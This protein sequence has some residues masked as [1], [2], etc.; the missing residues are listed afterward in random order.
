MIMKIFI[1]TYLTGTLIIYV[2]CAF[3][4]LHYKKGFSLRIGNW[5]A[6]DWL[7]LGILISFVGKI[8][9]AMYWQVAWTSYLKNTSLK[10][11]LLDYGTAANLPL[12]QLPI[13]LAC[14]CH[15]KA[16]HLSIADSYS[17]NKLAFYSM[18]IGICL[19]YSLEFLTTYISSFF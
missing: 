4:I 9:D 17:K 14:I 13:V 18:L 2:L 3:V 19:F 7:L 6:Y 11:S 12:R 5:K 16:A 1:E 10:Q 15:L 8:L